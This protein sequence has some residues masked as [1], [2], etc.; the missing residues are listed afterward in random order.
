MGLCQFLKSYIYFYLIYISISKVKGKFSLLN[1]ITK[2]V[3]HAKSQIKDFP[4]HDVQ[5][6]RF[7]VAHIPN[8]D[9]QSIED[10]PNHEVFSK[11]MPTN[12]SSALKQCS[13]LKTKV[14]MVNQARSAH[15]ILLVT[16]M[17]FKFIDWLQYINEGSYERLK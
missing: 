17:N 3:A 13:S 12:N 16:S 7:S 2:R 15:Y 8:I 1:T 6:W 10:F 4:N 14:T 9:K 11:T 5:S